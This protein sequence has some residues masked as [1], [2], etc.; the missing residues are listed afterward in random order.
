MLMPEFE[1]ITMVSAD[2]KVARSSAN[3][4]TLLYDEV[5]TPS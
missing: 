2:S 1:G 3:D 5:Q 4:L